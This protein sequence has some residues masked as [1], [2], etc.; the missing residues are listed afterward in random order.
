MEG[1]CTCGAIRY[2]L[3]DSPLVTHCCHC[4]WCQGM[5]GSAFI[6]NAW[7]ET[8]R[9]EL[10]RGM[11][12]EVDVPT[13]SGG[14]YRV[15]RC[16]SCA[17]ILWGTFGAPLFRFVRVGTLDAPGQLTPDVHI[18]T[19]TKVPWLNIDDGIPAFEEYYRR[20]EVWRPEAIERFKAARAAAG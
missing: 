11:P 9:V 19:S 10:M 1:G 3:T 18:Y 20:S 17:M 5:S 6:L 7:I 14:P 16:P 12:E 4:S 13:P 8:D 15:A 2:R